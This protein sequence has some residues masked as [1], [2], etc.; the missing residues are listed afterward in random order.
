MPTLK[1]LIEHAIQDTLNERIRSSTFDL[2]QFKLLK[3]Q[4][5]RLKYAKETLS[6]VGTSLEQST[7]SSRV[8]FLLSSKKVLKL[9]RVDIRDPKTNKKGLAQNATEIGHST[10]LPNLVTRV[11]DHAPDSSWLISELVRPLGDPDEFE[12][13]AGF[14]F[15]TLMM[16]FMNA[17]K[18]NY[19]INL[20]ISKFKGAPSMV[21]EYTR[22]KSWVA[23]PDLIKMLQS[24]SKRMTLGDFSVLDHWG[25]TP[26]GRVV[27]MDNGMTREVYHAFYAEPNSQ[28]AESVGMMAEDLFD[29]LKNGPDAPTSMLIGQ[30]ANL[31]TLNNAV[32]GRLQA[33]YDRLEQAR[34]HLEGVS[35][36]WHAVE[37]KAKVKLP[38]DTTMRFAV[39]LGTLS[40]SALEEYEGQVKDKLKKNGVV[41]E[42]LT[43]ATAASYAFSAMRNLFSM[44]QTLEE[45]PRQ[46]RAPKLLRAIRVAGMIGK[47]IE[48][49]G[50][51]YKVSDEISLVV[52]K[53]LWDRGFQ[54]SK[55]FLSNEDYLADKENARTLSEGLLYKLM[56]SF[57][58]FGG[59]QSILSVCVAYLKRTEGQVESAEWLKTL[60]DGLMAT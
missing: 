8:V 54:T 36:L 38:L 52:Y 23:F 58:S 19:D 31:V 20:T 28:M 33:L 6:P 44:F 13:L 60:H 3:S 30:R 47:K 27:L 9:A 15:R 48:D 45:I 1:S 26:D 34:L 41:P 46:F 14:N 12:P 40:R 18:D 2:A 11:F 16:F 37:T 10:S 29:V 21:A 56:L 35:E 59:I 32:S 17:K 7:G 4:V 42:S 43:V 57:H 25:K 53:E 39:G 5:A 49:K 22:L 24:G 55:T 50:V 51:V